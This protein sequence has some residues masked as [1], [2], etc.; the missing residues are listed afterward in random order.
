MKNTLIF[1]LLSFQHISSLYCQYE[2]K[3][4]IDTSNLKIQINAESEYYFGCPIPFSLELTSN[5]NVELFDLNTGYLSFSINKIIKGNISKKNYSTAAIGGWFRYSTYLTTDSIYET[6][7]EKVKQNKILLHSHEKIGREFDMV[8][9]F[10]KYLEPCEYILNIEYESHL[11]TSRKF[12]IVIDYQK[13]ITSI[14]NSI[15]TSKLAGGVSSLYLFY[16][17]T[18]Y[19][20]WNDSLTYKYQY[21]FSETPKLKLWWLTHKELILKIES[22]LNIPKYRQLNYEDK[23]HEIIKFSNSKNLQERINAISNFYEITGIQTTKPSP[24][25]SVVDMK[26]RVDEVQQ[27]WNSNKELIIWVNRVILENE[28]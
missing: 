6:D 23:I 26:N 16:Y 17:L 7:F 21:H 13:S 27:W 8:N 25:D 14:L 28:F 19:K 18:G 2:S 15:E 20:S 11:K 24:T 12:H 22:T 1:I 4:L 5:K 10:N 3:L 9:L